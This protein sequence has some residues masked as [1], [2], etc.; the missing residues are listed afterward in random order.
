MY[1]YYSSNSMKISWLLC[2]YSRLS[3]YSAIVMPLQ[4]LL[5]RIKILIKKWV[6][7]LKL[8]LPVK[9]PASTCGFYLGS[10]CH[11]QMRVVPVLSLQNFMLIGVETCLYYLD[12]LSFLQLLQEVVS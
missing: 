10:Q 3:S 5:R 9:A 7:C 8:F 1:Q 12:S 4:I 2:S 6:G 11:L